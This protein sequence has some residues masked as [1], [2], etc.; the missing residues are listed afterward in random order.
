[1]FN[2]LQEAG[3]A[4]LLAGVVGMEDFG[5]EPREDKNNIAPRFGFIFDPRG[6]SSLV[7]RGGVGRYFDFPYTNATL[8]F[9]VI[10]SQSAFGEIYA[11]SNSQGI[12]NADGSLFRVGQTLPPNEAVIDSENASTSAFTP[13]P[14]Q[15]PDQQ[16][17][18]SLSVGRNFAFEVDGMLTRP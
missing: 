4:G 9:P 1:M 5:S 14:R 16:F 17:G 15:P 6:D 18:F 8:L 7:V 11:A 12:R 13:L 3:R 10:D 2:D